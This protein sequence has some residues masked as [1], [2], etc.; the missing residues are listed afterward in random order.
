VVDSVQPPSNEPI[1]SACGAL[2]E[3]AL[4]GVGLDNVTVVVVYP[5]GN[6]AVPVVRSGRDVYG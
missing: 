6:Q 2:I 5:R 4:S 3:A 1:E